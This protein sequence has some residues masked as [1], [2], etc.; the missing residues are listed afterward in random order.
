MW[1][2]TLLLMDNLEGWVTPKTTDQSLNATHPANYLSTGIYHPFG[3]FLTSDHT[4]SGEEKVSDYVPNAIFG[5]SLCLNVAAILITWV[6]N[7]STKLSAKKSL[8]K[9]EVRW[10]LFSLT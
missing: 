1:N 3:I 9:G 8:T 10:F 2:F 4:T 6:Q 5:Y 7:I